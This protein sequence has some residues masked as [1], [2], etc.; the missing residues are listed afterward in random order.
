[1]AVVGAAQLDRAEA[2]G[3][4]GQQRVGA[5]AG[6][7]EGGSPGG[8]GEPAGAASAGRRPRRSGLQRLGDRAA[9]GENA[10]SAGACRPRTTASRARRSP[11]RSA[12]GMGE[13]KWSS[14]PRRCTGAASRRRSRPAAV[15]SAQDPRASV[16]QARRA[17][18]PSTCE[19]VDEA[20]DAA[21]RQHDPVGELAHPEAPLV[22]DRELDEGVVVGEGEAAFDLELRLQ[23]PRHHGVGLQEGDP[24]AQARIIGAGRPDDVGGGAGT[25]GALRHRSPGR[26]LARATRMIAPLRSGSCTRNYSGI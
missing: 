23:A 3:I 13:R 14:T 20:R 10:P 4:R 6:R 26:V 18:S 11:S 8:V 2:R 22:G 21:A 24:R 9:G 15:S 25:R 7:V 17:T 16:G 12:S 19:P 5:G 1:M